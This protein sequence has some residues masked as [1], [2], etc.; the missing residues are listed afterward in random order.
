MRYF[1]EPD[2]EA[3]ES[4]CLARDFGKDYEPQGSVTIPE[5][6]VLSCPGVSVIDID[7]QFLAIAPDTASWAFLT[8]DEHRILNRIAVSSGAMRAASVRTLPRSTDLVAALY[9]R[10]LVAIDGK[11]SIAGDVFDDS[12]NF[13][14]THLVELL[15]TEKCNLACGYCLAGTNPS[16]PSMTREVAERTIDLAYGMTE[17]RRISFEFSGG[18]PLM[19]FELLKHLASYIRR[20]RQRRGRDV[21]LL[22]QTNA[23][24]LTIERVRWLRDEGV[25]V[26]LSIDGGPEMHDK[27]RPMLGG[28]SSFR[29]VLRGVD[30]LQEFGVPFGVLVV[31]NRSNVGSAEALIDFL[32]DNEIRSIKLNPV[33]FLG[34]ARSAWAEFG[35]SQEEIVEYFKQFA[36]LLVRNG[37]PI[38]EDN[39]RTML[40]HLVSKTRPNRCLRTHCGAGD[41]FQAISASG[42]IYP[43]GRAT[44][45]PGLKLGNVTDDVTSLSEPGSRSEVI[46]QIRSRRPR[47]FDDCSVCPYRQLC[48]AG[49]SAQAFEKFGTVRHKTPE[50]HF[51]KSLYPFLMRWLSFD[52]HALDYFASSGYFG[53]PVSL[54]ARNFVAPT[55]GAAS[56][57]NF[58]AR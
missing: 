22:V 40:L 15:L 13:D 34:T 18:E 56:S 33:A 54:N 25:H 4:S 38:V 29:R 3:A 48:Q 39:L 14:E 47:D 9:R 2:R 5:D 24:L 53:T 35:L 31:L 49:C 55:R 26:G 19:Q 37:E 17:A 41:T 27:S 11:R 23:T 42:D 57:V 58:V 52:R 8:K 21:D 45:S 10:G 46:H 43:C 30:A 36:H 16:M 6:A 1:S 7:G 44:Q 51:Y 28:Q 32:V 12:P 50:C 20:H